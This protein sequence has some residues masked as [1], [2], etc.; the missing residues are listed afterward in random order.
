[1]MASLPDPAEVDAATSRQSPLAVKSSA[2]DRSPTLATRLL[3]RTSRNMSGTTG[4]RTRSSSISASLVDRRGRGSGHT[5]DGTSSLNEAARRSRKRTDD[6]MRTVKGVFKVTTTSVLP[7]DHIMAKL[8]EAI[9]KTASTRP[10]G[11]LKAKRKAAWLF[12]VDDTT[13]SVR[14]EIEVCKLDKLDRLLGVRFGRLRG[15]TWLYKQLAEELMAHLT[16]L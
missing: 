4:E 10:D 1:M 14:L 5:W 11:A 3:R 6:E 8:E 15:D 2:E 16:L 7:P 13:T 12:R 9:R